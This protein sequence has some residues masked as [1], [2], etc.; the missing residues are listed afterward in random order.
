MRKTLALL[1]S[2][3]LTLSLA[4]CA[5]GSGA[6]PKPSTLPV[7]EPVKVRA[8]YH[9]GLAGSIVPGISE[10]ET[11]MAWMFSYKK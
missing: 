8:A 3:I 4:G 11:P 7:A 5:A 10:K 6:E 2:L 9:P 1:V